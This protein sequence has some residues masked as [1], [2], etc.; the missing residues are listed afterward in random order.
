MNNKKLKSKTAKLKNK[1]TKKRKLEDLDASSDDE[2]IQLKDTRQSDEPVPK[3]VCF[4]TE[5][6]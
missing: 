4:P 6:S 1:A 3:K 5:L 2:G